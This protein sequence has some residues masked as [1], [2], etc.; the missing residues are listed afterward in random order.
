[1]ATTGATEDKMMDAVTALVDL[2]GNKLFGQ[3]DSIGRND[4]P[5]PI[6]YPAAFVYFLFARR[7]ESQ[8]RPVYDWY[9]DVVVM[10]QNLEGERALA[11]DAYSL[12][13]AVRDAIQGK[14]FGLTG[15]GPFDCIDVRLGE[16]DGGVIAYTLGFRTKAYLPV[17]TRQ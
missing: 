15:I 6:C 13:E 8:P 16:L 3:V 2:S 12:F 1:M 11:K 4:T 10:S 14:D 9:F 17:P 7:T 5:P